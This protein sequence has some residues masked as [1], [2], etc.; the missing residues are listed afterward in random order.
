VLAAGA[1]RRVGVLAL[2]AFVAAGVAGSV[3][4][5]AGGGSGSA[6]S[7]RWWPSPRSRRA[8]RCCWPVRP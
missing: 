1:E 5:L 8:R 7:R 2:V 6:R 4:H 3:M